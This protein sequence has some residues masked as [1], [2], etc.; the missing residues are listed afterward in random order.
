MIP[1]R[2]ARSRIG[3]PEANAARKAVS[4]VPPLNS[5]RQLVKLLRTP[6]TKNDIIGISDFFNK[7]RAKDFSFPFFFTELFHSR[8]AKVI[9]DGSPLPVK[10]IAEL[11]W[12][13]FVSQSC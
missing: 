7:T 4:V 10:E 9:F 6:A 2:S 8:F 12:R 13:T 5:V 3:L 1:L 11:Q